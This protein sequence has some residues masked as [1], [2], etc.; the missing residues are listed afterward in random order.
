MFLLIW[1]PYFPLRNLIWVLS[2][3]YL[4]TT[5]KKLSQT[6]FYIFIFNK[7]YVDHLANF[8]SSRET[9]S[10]P[11]IESTITLIDLGTSPLSSGSLGHLGPSF[12]NNS[13]TRNICNFPSIY[14]TSIKSPIVPD[15]QQNHVC[16]SC[17]KFKVVA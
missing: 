6:I 13:K 14:N 15:S 12:S 4:L 16:I 11:G 10:R 1:S 7:D 17:W 5:K 3:Q 9:I 2:P 8:S